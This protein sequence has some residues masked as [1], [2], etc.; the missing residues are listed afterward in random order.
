MV[1]DPNGLISMK[2]GVYTENG[3]SLRGVFIIDP[4]GVIQVA[5]IHNIPIGRNIDEVY[6]AL[7]AAQYSYSHPQEGVPANWQPGQKGVPTGIEYV[8]KF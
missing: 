6:R 5:I 2:Y 7:K 4:K 3:I 1:A 8:G